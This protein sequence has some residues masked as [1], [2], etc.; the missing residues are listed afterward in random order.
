MSGGGVSN[1]TLNLSKNFK[2]PLKIYDDTLPDGISLSNVDLIDIENYPTEVVN[3]CNTTTN[4]ET[5]NDIDSKN[6][7]K[8]QQIKIG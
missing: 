6:A 2:V 1:D 7:I 4:E 5:S 8:L 3:I